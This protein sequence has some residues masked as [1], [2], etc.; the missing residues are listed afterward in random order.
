MSVIIYLVKY[1]FLGSKFE[2]TSSSTSYFFLSRLDAICFVEWMRAQNRW[3]KKVLLKHEN[4][5]PNSS[6]KL[7]VKRVKPTSCCFVW[8]LPLV[9]V[10][11]QYI[12]FIF[13]LLNIDSTEQ[14]K[15]QATGRNWKMIS[16]VTSLSHQNATV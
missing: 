8:Q 1:S 2:N 3:L 5:F 9:C 16:I 12:N 10:R 6:S 7:T 14:F 15:T 4:K 11:D 13:C